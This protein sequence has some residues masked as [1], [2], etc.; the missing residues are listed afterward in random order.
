MYFIFVTQIKQRLDRKCI[1]IG[2]ELVVDILVQSD[3]NY[4]N[5]DYFLAFKGDDESI[6]FPSLT[7]ASQLVLVNK[8]QGN[9]RACQEFAVQFDVRDFIH[10][11]IDEHMQK[12]VV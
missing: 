10:K 8:Q 1:E 12:R 7:L 11:T 6:V 4:Q 2:Q 5:F 9:L 3:E